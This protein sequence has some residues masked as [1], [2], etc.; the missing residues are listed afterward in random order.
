MQLDVRYTLRKT[1]FGLKFDSFCICVTTFRYSFYI[2]KG[3][4]IV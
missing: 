3:K 1:V 4:L 2:A